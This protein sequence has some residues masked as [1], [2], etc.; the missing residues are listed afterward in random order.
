MVGHREAGT[1]TDKI[2]V[3]ADLLLDLERELRTLD[4]WDQAQ[5]DPD[6]LASTLPF[7]ADRLAIEQWLQWVFIPTIKQQI[8]TGVGLPEVCNIHPYAEE[9]LGQATESHGKLLEILLRI[10]RH[11]TQA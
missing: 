9:C 11:L 3:M 2:S 10:D 6:T 4:R 8:E 7:G 1:V 5:P